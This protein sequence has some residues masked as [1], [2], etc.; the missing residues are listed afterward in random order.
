MKTHKTDFPL[1][2]HDATG[3]I[4]LLS[5]QGTQLTESGQNESVML[6]NFCLIVRD[7]FVL[8]KET[9]NIEGPFFR[10]SVTREAETV[11]LPDSFS[12]QSLY[13]WLK[14][15]PDPRLTIFPQSKAIQL[16]ADSVRL[17]LQTNPRKVFSVAHSGWNHLDD[18]WAYVIGEKIFLPQEVDIHDVQ[19]SLK[20]AAYEEGSLADEANK[21]LNSAAWFLLLARSIPQVTAPLCLYLILAIIYT[22]LTDIAVFPRFWLWVVGHSGSGKTSI[23]EQSLCFLPASERNSFTISLTSTSAGVNYLLGDQ[24]DIPMILDDFSSS[25]GTQQQRIYRDLIDTVMRH[26][27]NGSG[28][29][30][31]NGFQKAHCLAVV[32]A[33]APL[34]SYSLASRSLSIFVPTQIDFSDFD[35][36]QQ[37]SHLATFVDHFLAWLVAHSDIFHIF[38]A[39]KFWIQSPDYHRP[40]SDA[41]LTSHTRFLCAAQL[42]LLKYLQDIEFPESILWREMK[43]LSAEVRKL[44]ETNTTF[45]RQLKQ[46]SAIETDT[47]WIPLLSRALLN[48]KNFTFGKSAGDLVDFSIDACWH[49]GNIAVKPEAILRFLQQT[50]P[51]KDWDKQTIYRALDTANLVKPGKDGKTTRVIGRCGR[52]LVFATENLRLHAAASL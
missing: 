37:D 33:E 45:L 6:S 5:E 51:S 1:K 35:Q 39:G 24:Y 10:L 19:S 16:I 21:K 2:I 8:V 48:E 23:C 49:K 4:F 11:L 28:R 22:R 40:F 47:D 41:R 17:Q 13:K 31:Q 32:T 15:M 29:H 25:E 9:G 27:T 30:T 34:E 20:L 36:I 52:V 42:L 44:G 46:S 38:E 18:R 43:Y 7:F 14:A 3:R 50:Y 12:M 26:N